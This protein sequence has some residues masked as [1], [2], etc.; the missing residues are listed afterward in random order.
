MTFVWH[1][2]EGLSSGGL[3]VV[4]H[5]LYLSSLNLPPPPPLLTDLMR[6][7]EIRSAKEPPQHLHM[8]SRW[9]WASSSTEEA[10]VEEK[11]SIHDRSIVASW[12]R[13]GGELAIKLVS[14]LGVKACVWQWGAPPPLPSTPSACWL[15]WTLL[16]PPPAGTYP[17]LYEGHS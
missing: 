3:G 8:L 12:Q 10:I 17:P 15:P 6:P 14:R 7:T 13:L 5:P 11:C 16:H 1:I 4:P 2:R 9:K